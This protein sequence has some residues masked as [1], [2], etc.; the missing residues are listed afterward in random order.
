MGIKYLRQ[1][2]EW[3]IGLKANVFERARIK[4][5]LFYLIITV[6]LLFSF[7]IALYYNYSRSIGEDIE[8]N[9]TD[10]E[11][12][13]IIEKNTTRLKILLITINGSAILVIGIIS[14]ILSGITLRPI[15]KA[16]ERERQF[17]SDAAHELRTP[18]A[19]MK[20][21]LEVAL[22]EPELSKEDINSLI[23]SNLEEIDRMTRMTENLLSLSHIDMRENK[24]N[25]SEILFS[26]LVE[27]SIEKM[28]PYAEKKNITL[29]ASIP[30][31]VIILGDKDRIQQLLFNLLKNAIDYNKDK[32]KVE[33][34]INLLPKTILLTISD[35]GIGISP[36]DLPHIFE[37]FYR[38]DKAR[39]H[40][41]V[42]SGLGLSIVKAIV[43]THH[44]TIQVKSNLG[45]GTTVEIQ[46][47]R[48]N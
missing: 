5:T 28:R 8:G 37:R 26:H 36:Q 1:L 39:S 38:A 32:G 9:F 21:E 34:R 46:F 18:L 3:V 19:I 23:M 35:T 30:E 44:G 6:L 48:I 25:L 45:E 29:R 14:F 40:K 20:T 17:T 2:E 31:K 7:S 12:Q 33:V 4:L 41:I 27:R 42:G 16:M 15:R 24:I 22:R 11:Q 13:F 10:E 47:P 43:N